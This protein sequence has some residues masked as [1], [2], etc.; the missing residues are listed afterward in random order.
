MHFASCPSERST[1]NPAIPMED[2]AARRPHIAGD[3]TP[4]EEIEDETESELREL[5]R[6]GSVSGGVGGIESGARVHL[7][8]VVPTSGAAA[9]AAASTAAAASNIPGC[10]AAASGDAARA[11]TATTCTVARPSR[12][13]S[14]SPSSQQ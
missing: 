1:L 12:G 13:P 2:I 5:R 4:R 6:S 11:A 10:A 14:Q 7:L 3:E 9:A 8:A